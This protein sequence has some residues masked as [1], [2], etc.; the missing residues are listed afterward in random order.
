MVFGHSDIDAVD[1]LHLLKNKRN[2]SVEDVSEGKKT[3]NNSR[4]IPSIS[5]K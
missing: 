1:L 2:Y 3:Y 5:I 4:K